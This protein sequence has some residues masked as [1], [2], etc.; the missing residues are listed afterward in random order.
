MSNQAS[1]DV[2]QSTGSGIHAS[3]NVAQRLLA[4]N[5]NVNA[6]RTQDILRKDEW[7]KFDNTVVSVA[8][9]RLVA[10]ADLIERGL[11]YPIENALGIT[12]IEWE[13]TGDLGP[14]I[15]SMNGLTQGQNDRLEFDLQSVPVPIIHKDFH[16]NIRTLEASRRGGQP[17]DVQQAQVAARIVSEAIETLLFDGSN[18]TGS[19]SKIYGYTTEP[20]RITGSTTGSWATE[21]GANILSDLMA[22]VGA[23]HADNMYG[24]YMLYVS[25]AALVNLADDYKAESDKTIMQRLLDVP[26]VLGIRSTTNLT[27]DEAVLVQMTSDVV[28]IVDGIQPTVIMWETHGGMLLNFK[29]MAIMVPRVKSD[30]AGQSG[31][32][33]YS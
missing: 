9:S 8:R 1:I 17:L 21:S 18:I 16:I 28:D 31:V 30:T 22:M 11:T 7:I 14:A 33:H 25:P 29:V 5:F 6:L 4:S 27:N 24:P 19:S 20:N 3:G 13:R 15:V 10:V 26:G 23:A 32:V 2:V 12:K